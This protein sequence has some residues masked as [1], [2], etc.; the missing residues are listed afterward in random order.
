M[1]ICQGTYFLNKI[2]N[3]EYFMEI[4]V[5][6]ENDHSEN[7]LECLENYFITDKGSCFIGRENI[8]I[9]IRKAFIN[10]AIERIITPSKLCLFERLFILLCFD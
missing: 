8:Q 2:K 9:N 6:I 1:V 3:R 4:F 5:Y 7:W 10:A